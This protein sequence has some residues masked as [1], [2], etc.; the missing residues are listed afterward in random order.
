MYA[1]PAGESLELGD[2]KPVVV[3]AQPV[4]ANALPVAFATPVAG[5]DLTF[6]NPLRKLVINQHIKVLEAITGG[7]IEQ[8]NTYTVFDAE[9]GRPVFLVQEESDNCSRCCCAP[10][11]SFALKFLAINPDGSPGGVLM[12]MERNGNTLSNPC[13]KWL[14]CCNLAELCSDGFSLHAGDVSHPDGPGHFP[15]QNQIGWANQPSLGGG[16]TPTVQLMERQELASFAIVE[17]PTCFG[18]CSEL[19]FSSPFQISRG[20]A[21]NLPLKRGDSARIVKQKP[22]GFGGALREALTDSD[23]Y[24]MEYT[25][26]NLN[27]YQKATELAALFMVDYMFFEQDNGMCKQEDGKIKITC[28]ICYCFG[29][30]CPCNLVLGGNND[31]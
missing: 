19:C 8:A 20:P 15:K 27:P 14:C 5:V 30:L 10:V 23:V 18:G 11:H 28:F 31:N 21:V 25:D 2:V 26:P 24:T 17:G 6:L 12:T 9:A 13:N 29:C 3:S 1:R 7:C 4:A 16:L 22:S